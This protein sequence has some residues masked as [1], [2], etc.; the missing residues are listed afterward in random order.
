MSIDQQPTQFDAAEGIPLRP[1]PILAALERERVQYVLVGGLAAQL[2]GDSAPTRGVDICPDPDPANLER[3]RA[4]LVGLRAKQWVPG[5]GHPLQMPM[6]RRRLDVD[7]PLL[8]QTIAGAFDII[9][10]PLGIPGGYEELAARA[11]QRSAYGVTVRIAD[12][13]HLLESA[14]TSTRPK[15]GATVA[16]LI[17][18]DDRTRRHGVQPARQTL[19]QA[20]EPAPPTLVPV[21]DITAGLTA[22]EHLAIV[23][24]DVRPA[25]EAARQAVV[26]AIAHANEDDPDTQHERLFHIQQ[27]VHAGLEQTT[28]L[29]HELHPHLSDR[30]L[31]ELPIEHGI[32]DTSATLAYQINDE[33]L[34]ARRIIND[35]SAELCQNEPIDIRDQLLEARIHLATAASHAEHLEIHLERTARA[36]EIAGHPGG[37]DL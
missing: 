26:R 19:D 13:G 25:V 11:H 24:D 2:H 16:R 8:T 4:T 18:L 1:A 6:E 31:C 17:L 34:I 35:A 29:R 3:L 27:I 30:Q 22:A 37:L 28:K 36:W 23:F 15:D 33:L 12:L 10:I 7:T 32:D 20:P 21:D 5:F 9:P 14:R